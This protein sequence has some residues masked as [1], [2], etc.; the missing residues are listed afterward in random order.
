M[1]ALIG[2]WKQETTIE[3]RKQISFQMQELFNKQ[4]TSLAVYY[5]EQNWAYDRINSPIGWRRRATA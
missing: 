3:G 4:P 5:P 1:D 2:Q